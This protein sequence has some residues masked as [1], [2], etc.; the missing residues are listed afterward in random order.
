MIRVLQVILLT[1]LL[2]LLLIS[3]FLHLLI[4]LEDLYILLHGSMILLPLLLLPCMLSASA[5]PTILYHY[6]V[7]FLPNIMSI[8]ESLS[9]SQA[10]DDLLWVDAM[11]K[12]LQ[13]LESNHTWDLTSFPLGHTTLFAKGVFKLK[14]KTNGIVDR[15]KAWLVIRGFNQQLGIDYKH[16]FS[17]VAKLTTVRVLI[18]LASFTIGFCSTLMS[19]MLFLM[20]F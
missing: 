12:E 15:P 6:H 8:Q 18:A 1:F 13:A 5:Y 16:A 20:V 10:K 11:N 14:F 17:P 7:T 9:Y 2:L 19:T 4:P 3:L